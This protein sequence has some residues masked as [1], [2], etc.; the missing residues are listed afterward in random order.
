MNKETQPN[1]QTS[2]KVIKID[3][4]DMSPE[5]A[6]KVVKD[7]KDQSRLKRV[8]ID[9]KKPVTIV[10]EIVEEVVNGA[11]KVEE[12]LEKGKQV[13]ADSEDDY[14]KSDNKTPSPKTTFTVTDDFLHMNGKKVTTFNTPHK[15][16]GHNICDFVVIHYTGSHGTFSSSSRWSGDPKSKVSWHITIGRDGSINQSEHGFRAVLWHAGRSEWHAKQNNRTYKSLNKYSIGIEVSNAGKLSKVQDYY[17]NPYGHKYAKNEVFID[18]D[19]VAW[20]KF[21]PEQIKKVEQVALALAKEYNCVDIVGHE[22]IAPGRKIDPGPAFPL[23]RLQ[24]KLYKK[25]WYKFK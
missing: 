25:P 23:E 24:D 7:I 21:T 15:S 13:E 6:E 20:E 18:S 17:V 22:D 12:P 8:G 5:E 1:E 10:E 14:K 9:P 2:R 11:E 19:G 4:G 3:V 16:S